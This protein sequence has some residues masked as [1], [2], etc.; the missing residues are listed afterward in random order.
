METFAMAPSD[1]RLLWFLP[2]FV[3][4]LL[5]GV[6]A[7]LIGTA[8]GSRGAKF[9][10]STE[11]LRLRGDLY[12]RLIPAASLRAETIRRV[13]LAV[14]TGL[15][16]KWRTMGTAVPGYQSGWYRLKSGEKA[17]LY[18]TDRKRAV[19]LATAEGYGVLLSPENPD[20]FVTAV[21]AIA[22]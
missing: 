12:G 18:L 20:A 15:A 21:R 1:S 10:V 22:K 7:L 2:V 13:D 11:G 5:I 9:E 19:Y 16:P 4:L 6:V 8:M 17:L 3:G 14:D